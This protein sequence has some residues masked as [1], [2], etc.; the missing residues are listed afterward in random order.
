LK[1]QNQVNAILAICLGLFAMVGHAQQSCPVDISSRIIQNGDSIVACLPGAPGSVITDTLAVKDVT[2]YGTRFANNEIWPLDQNPNTPTTSTWAPADFNIGGI[3]DQ[4]VFAVGIN[5]DDG[6][7]YTASTRLWGEPTIQGQIAAPLTA[8]PTGVYRID[9]STGVVTLIVNITADVDPNENFGASYVTYD[10][11]SDQVFVVGMDTGT[12]YRIDPDGSGAAAVLQSYNPDIDA[13]IAED[14]VASELAPRGERILGLAWN[15]GDERLYYSVWAVDVAEEGSLPANTINNTI[16]SVALDI[17]GAIDPATDI[18]V[19]TLPFIDVIQENNI[20]PGTFITLV[21]DTS[22]P[23]GDIEFNQLGDRVLLSETGFDSSVPATFAHRSRLLEYQLTAGTWTLVGNQS[24]YGIGESAATFLGINARGGAA[25]SYGNITAPQI[26]GRDDFL[27]ATGDVLSIRGPGATYYGYQFM[28]STQPGIVYSSL[29][30]DLTSD[31]DIQGKGLFGDVDVFMCGFALG[32]FVW[33]DTNLDGDQDAGEP[34]VAGVQVEL[35]TGTNCGNATGITAAT[36]G[37]GIYGIPD[38]LPGTYSLQ[39][40]NLPAGAVISTADQGGDD[41]LDSDVNPAT[42]CLDSVIIT[43]NDVTLDMG[44]SV[45]GSIGDKVWCDGPAATSDGIFTAG[46][47]LNNINV[48]LFNDTNCDGSA[49]GA[50]VS[51]AVT[52]TDGDYLFNNLATGPT[53]SSVCYVT[54]VDTADVD[55]GACNTLGSASA[56]TAGQLTQDAANDLTHDYYFLV[57]V[58]LGDFVWYDTNRNGIQDMGEP[59]VNGVSVDLYDNAA[60]TGASVDNTT[61]TNGGSPASDGFYEFTGLVPTMHCVEFSNLP[62]GAVVSLANQGGDDTLDS[63]VDPV[64]RQIQNINLIISDPTNDMGISIPGSLGDM[65]WCDGGAATNDGVFTAGEGLNNITV[66]LFNDTNCDGAAD[67]ASIGNQVTAG[68]GDYLFANLA[69]GPNG[70]P[71][72]YATQV[73]TADADLGSCNTL[74]SGSATTPGQLTQG[75]PDDLTHDYYFVIDVALGDF[76]WFD[77]NQDGV[78]GAGEPGLNGVDA[79][80]FD[81]ATCT[82]VSIDSATTANGGTPAADGFYEF[83]GLATGTYCVQFSSLPAGHQFTIQNTPGDDAVDSDV[84]PANGQIQNINLNGND[85]TNDAGV[86]LNGSVAGITWCESNTNTNVTYDPGDGDSPLSN[87]GVTLYQDA[88]CSNTIDGSDASTAVS[89]S[90][91]DPAGTYL[92][93]NL[94]VGPVGAELCYITEVD[95]A[96]PDLALCDTAIT[97]TTLGPDLDTGS[98]DSVDNNFGFDDLVALGDVVF[99]DNDQNGIQDAGEPGVNGITVNLYANA[100][101]AAPSQATATTANGGSPATD[102]YY[103]FMG[104]DVGTYCVEFAGL[105]AGYVFTQQ[106]IGDDGQDSD[107]DPVTGQVQNINLIA[108][109]PSIDAGIYAAIG[110]VSGTL[111]CDDAPTNGVLDAG[112]EVSGVNVDVFR[113]EGC[114]NTSDIFIDNVATDGAGSF[115]FNNLPVALAP[116][117]PNPQVCYRLAFNQNAPELQG[118][119]RPITPPAI[120]VGVDTGNPTAP[121]IVFG[122]M[123]VLIVPINH[124]WALI[125]LVAAILLLVRRQNLLKR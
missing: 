97:V 116:A 101:C 52:M 121:P 68:D 55:L 24:R 35:H 106:N 4:N 102:G 5:P 48:N 60:C 87:I 63:D 57:D 51:T 109:D 84:N 62:A 83:T 29:V 56:M 75:A 103:F 39:F 76:V 118:C 23:V 42:A 117:P 74:D 88:N 77:T 43:A 120:S 93:S 47:G 54:Q 85:P 78:Q 111:Y 19:I 18:L 94:P 26:D 1:N 72:C 90:T 95:A 79:D 115:V 13:G 107:A 67:G 98:P 8:G 44:I 104:L 17:N 73:D 105:P 27:L 58:T 59:G 100:T 64:T 61:T 34:G 45:P 46:E 7:I 14:T 38:I 40:S 21:L 91:A 112:E 31:P 6:D 65:V 22:V 124:P 80:L 92:F 82:G 30:A 50:S 119:N 89:M 66:N 16:R 122:T 12:I 11:S 108:T 110:S 114:D 99:Y 3:G 36:D 33:Y 41:T 25:W 49:D 32:D 81:N 96:D 123:P 20:A 2:S 15:P 28:P 125:I 37:S 70:S 10:E 71:V 53:G 69:T 9:G 113:D 86:F